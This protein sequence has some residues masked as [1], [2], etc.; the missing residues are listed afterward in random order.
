MF[1]LNLIKT[2]LHIPAIVLLLLLGCSKNSPGIVVPPVV[3]P[4]TPPAAPVVINDSLKNGVNLQPSYYNGGNPNFGWDL[5]K[6]QTKIK[7]L[8]I[9]IEP[10]KAAQAKAW[11]TQAKANGFTV[12]ATYHKYTVLGSDNA[13]E[14]IAAA[15]WWKSNYVALGGNFT[16]NLMN[17]WGSHNISASDYAAAYNSAIETVRTVYAGPIIIDIPGWGQET[18]TAYQAVKTSSPKIIDTNII[19]SAHIYPNGWNQG[20]NHHIQAADLDDITNSGRRGIIG[21][22][23]NGITGTADWSA[24]VD[25]AKAKGWPVL[26]WCWNGDGGSMNMADP[27][28]AAGGST[29]SSFSKSTYFPI[30]YNKL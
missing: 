6:L 23:G 24:I 14:L 30:I 20:R 7:T 5:M 11:I 28:W 15:N 17:E 25:R 18:Y 16:I 27:S 29:A 21:E 10:D 1:I 19:L 26:G 13:L 8:R 22:F 9:E 2:M 4:V 3:P 12:I